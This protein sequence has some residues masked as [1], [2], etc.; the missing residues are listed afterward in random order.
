[1]DAT[2]AES[3]TE[4]DKQAMFAE[5]QTARRMQHY[6]FALDT[7]ANCAHVRFDVIARTGT[8]QWDRYETRD[9]RTNYRCG[10]GGFPVVV[11]A[12]CDR[13]ERDSKSSTTS[14]N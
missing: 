13:H 2:T 3:T 7:C 5:H 8:R 12:T 9:V 4:A 14:E 10:V 1:M 6:R 11:R